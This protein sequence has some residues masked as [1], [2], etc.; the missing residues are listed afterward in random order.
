[1]KLIFFNKHPESLAEST[2]IFINNKNLDAEDSNNLKN[3]FSNL[4][5]KKLIFLSH[6]F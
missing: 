6:I 2:I 4:K 1:M 5:G 3:Y